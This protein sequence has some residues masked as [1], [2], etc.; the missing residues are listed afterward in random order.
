MLLGLGLLS[1]FGSPN[2][3]SLVCLGRI[4]IVDVLNMYFHS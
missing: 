4:P 2:S 1:A 3:S